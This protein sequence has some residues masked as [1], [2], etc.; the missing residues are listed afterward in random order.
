MSII[1]WAG[2]CRWYVGCKIL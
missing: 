1:T 2:L